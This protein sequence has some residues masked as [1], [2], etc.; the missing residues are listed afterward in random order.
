MNGNEAGLSR[1]MLSNDGELNFTKLDKQDRS[2]L[3]C[4]LQNDDARI[5]KLLLSSTKTAQEEK[6]YVNQ[7]NGNGETPL[8]AVCDAYLSSKNTGPTKA[9]RELLKSKEIDVNATNESE[10]T[11]LYMACNQ[12]SE[13]KQIIQ[14]LLEDERCDMNIPSS[15]GDTPFMLLCRENQYPILDYMYNHKRANIDINCINEN[16]ETALILALNGSYSDQYMDEPFQLVHEKTDGKYYFNLPITYWEDI[17]GGKINDKDYSKKNFK[18]NFDNEKLREIKQKN[19]WKQSER[20]EAEY[21]LNTVKLILNDSKFNCIN[22]VNYSG[23]CALAYAC[24]NIREFNDK[25]F[26]MV[27]LLCNV[28]GIRY[29]DD[30]KD[31]DDEDVYFVAPF[32][33][34]GQSCNLELLKYIYGKFPKLNV[35][36]RNDLKYTAFMHVFENMDSIK[37]DNVKYESNYGTP[38]PKKTFI[39]CVRWL[40]RLPGVILDLKDDDGRTAFDIAFSRVSYEGVFKDEEGQLGLQ[41]FIDLFSPD[42]NNDTIPHK[43]KENIIKQ[44]CAFAMAVEVSQV[45]LS[46][47]RVKW[48]MKHFGKYINKNVCYCGE[49]PLCR[50]IDGDDEPDSDL[51]SQEY[52]KLVKYLVDTVG[53]DLN[54]PNSESPQKTA[55]MKAVECNKIKFFNLFITNEKYYSKMN[56][57][58]VDEDGKSIGHY[59]FDGIGPASMARKLLK[60]KQFT[61]TQLKQC[62]Q[63]AR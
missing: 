36:G 56:L 53:I 35:N 54:F 29:L 62:K 33:I 57:L 8:I 43:W 15:T 41:L 44:S 52:L 27:K 9:V 63:G 19:E 4:A 42:S 28:K 45:E 16:R 31:E 61:P 11:A 12:A 59:V 50:A 37:Y 26:E 47:Q 32:A 22:M 6:R 25:N 24:E 46:I 20:R 30:W 51:K 3:I 1:F 49:S 14:L 7:K 40:T 2:V 39:E 58:Y 10:E 55:I 38:I 18:S 5:V 13:N 34:A 17:L 60:T 21:Q 23:N 48:L